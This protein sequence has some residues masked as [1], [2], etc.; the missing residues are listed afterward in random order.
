MG[1]FNVVPI[2]SES[3]R[4]AFYHDMLR[5]LRAFDYML[6]EGLIEQRSD[7]IGAEQELCLISANGCPQSSAL[8]IL[9]RIPDERYTNELALYNLEVNLSPQRL[10][11]DCF[12]QTEAELRQCLVMGRKAAAQEQAEILLAGILPTLNFRHLLFENMTPEERY[13]VLSQELLKLRGSKFEIFLQG[14][15]DFQ[16]TLDSVLFEACNTSFQL[17]LQVD[18]ND[19]MRMHNWAQLISGPV[20][21]ACANSPLLFG[22]ELW[23][24]NRIAL[25]KQSLDTR[26]N[27]NHLRVMMPRV[28]FGDRWLNGSAAELWKK[29]VVRFPVLLK[30][31]GDDDPFDLLKQGLM[32]KLKSIRLHNGTTYTWN[33]LC[34]GVAN[35]SP[36][37]RIECRYLPS[38]PSVQDEIANFAF[39]I[40]LMKGMP[41]EMEN[42]WE[43][44]D[45][46][47]AK[48]NFVKAA[49]TGIHTVLHWNGQNY[50]AKDLLLS[51]FLPMAEQGLKRVGIKDDDVRCYL[52]VI[53]RRISSEN[54]GAQW[55]RNSFRHLRKKLKPAVAA[56]YLV[57]Q[58][59][60]YQKEDLPVHE[61]EIMEFGK[62]HPQVIEQDAKD[63]LVEDLM[64]RDVISVRDNVCLEVVEQIL[65]WRQINHL[66]IENEN[67][68]LVGMI[69]SSLLAEVDYNSQDL[70][71]S[72]M[73]PDVV[74]V[75]PAA[76]VAEAE[77]VLQDYQIGCLPV[78]ENGAL[79]GLLTQRDF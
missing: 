70:A 21:S 54:T 61:W 1:D 5:D 33:R 40:G 20:L 59:L 56:R 2:R 17:H 35:N 22:K 52:S 66:P 46:R 25:F 51:T 58:M 29:D 50:A 9:D 6:K 45:F 47:V 30:G 10:Q 8:S 72:V 78:L 18:P 4:T 23:A 53:E 13:K 67:G 65:K 71:R 41:P 7:H 44:T 64:H 37:I 3:D 77:Q 11:G 63:K 73:I 27:K 49:R 79:V 68:E 32:P 15:D 14:V 31:Y 48:S 69:S 19:F 55:Q 24:E 34:Y 16:A 75:S 60:E 62:L 36:H 28:Y 26:S 74:T 42:F 39:W 38:G 76:R 43:G 57:Q 12:A